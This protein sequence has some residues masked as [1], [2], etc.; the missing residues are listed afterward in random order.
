M[1]SSSESSHCCS[2]DTSNQPL[3]Y[4]Q[5]SEFSQSRQCRYCSGWEL[6]LRLC[7][8]AEHPDLQLEGLRESQSCHSRAS[9]GSSPS[10]P[11]ARPCRLHCLE[12]HSHEESPFRVFGC[13]GKER[14]CRLFA[15][16]VLLEGCP[17]TVL[18]QSLLFSILTI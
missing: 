18:Q 12:C 9:S 1:S 5:T 10:P 6:V 2:Y 15:L 16:L 8:S 13:A 14:N 4:L 11:L 3:R 17:T 7:P